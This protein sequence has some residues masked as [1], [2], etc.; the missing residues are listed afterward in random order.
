MVERIIFMLNDKIAA[1][2]IKSTIQARRATP[3]K[4]IL[5][6][7]LFFIIQINISS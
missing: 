6:E 2:K 5:L 4:F 1:V 7:Q 3:M